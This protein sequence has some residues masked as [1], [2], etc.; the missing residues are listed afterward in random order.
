MMT[1][2]EAFEAAAAWSSSAIASFT[3]YVSITFAYLTVAFVAGRRLS[4]FQTLVVSALYVFAATSGVM[5]TITDLGMLEI[6]IEHSPAAVAD[7]PFTSEGFWQGYQAVLMIVG[8]LIS[9]YFMWNVRQQKI[10]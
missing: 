10:E 5:S 4:R 7:V 8:I 9:L 6:A 1:E 2:A 3:I